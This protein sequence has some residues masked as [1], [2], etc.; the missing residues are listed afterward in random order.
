MVTAA[1]IREALGGSGDVGEMSLR[2]AGGT[3]SAALFY[4]DGL[5]SSSAVN[6]FVLKPLL[7]EAL[8][9][10]EEGAVAFI[11]SGG[12][13]VNSSKVTSDPGECVASILSG[14]CAVVF[15]TAG[16]AVLFETKGF[17]VRGISEP[18]DENV[19]KGAK[20]S[21]IEPLRANTS[22]IRMKIKNPR[23]RVKQLTLGKQTSTALAILYVEG[24]A[25]MEIVDKLIKRL[26]AIDADGILAPG[27]IEDCIVDS[28]F[29][30]FPQAEYTERP[31]KVC[32]GLLEGRA[33][34]IIDGLPTVYIV[35][36][37]LG[38]LMQAPEDYSFNYIV[39]SMTRLI[40]YMCLALTLT[41]PGFY[42]A[43]LCF[44]HEMIPLQ[45]ALSFI[46]NQRGTPFP[47]V[48]ETLVMLIAFELLTQAGLRLPKTVGQA[49]SIIGGII[50]GQAAVSAKLLS[51]A[52]IV[53]VSAAGI[54][55]FCLPGQDFA[56]SVRVARLALTLFAAAAGLYGLAAGAVL[57]VTHLASLESFGVPYLSPYASPEPK[58]A[59][60]DTIL[61]LPMTMYRRRPAEF[62]SPNKRRRK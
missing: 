45:L 14:F 54:A 61:R 21:F 47:V 18:T 31:D 57:L 13:Y 7:Q 59:W 40:R 33:A 30:L 43:M 52:V 9:A 41:L 20:D 50:V 2:P 22:L 44:H 60:A 58:E 62:A 53:V 23:L 3:L 37:T 35:P 10:D 48:V 27:A 46:K 36:A 25:N 39:S 16:K 55:G 15:D 11:S 24:V 19:I 38:S 51:P 49:A 29:T 12:V 4:I 17:S 42:V 56:G 1:M 8:P 26:G 6:D 34:L 28:R 32:A 5:V